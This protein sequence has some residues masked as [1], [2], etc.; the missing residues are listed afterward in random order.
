MLT[1]EKHRRIVTMEQ[2]KIM[3]EDL[4][5]EVK[6]MLATCFAGAV[7]REGDILYLVFPNGQEFCAC[8][9]EES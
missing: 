4:I 3:L 8:V 2:S 6:A 9:K 1:N 5:E 7:R